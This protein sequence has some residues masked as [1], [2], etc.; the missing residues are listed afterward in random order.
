MTLYVIMPA[1]S[2]FSITAT[3]L[4]TIFWILCLQVFPTLGF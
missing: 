2:A 1:A 3:L 4:Q